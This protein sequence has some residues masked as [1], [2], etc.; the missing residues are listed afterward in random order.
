MLGIDTGAPKASPT[1]GAVFQSTPRYNTCKIV[2]LSNLVWGVTG[3]TWHKTTHSKRCCHEIVPK[4]SFK[5]ICNMKE[6]GF[7]SP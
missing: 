3:N 2:D 4:T 6:H 5:I 1:R 7:Q